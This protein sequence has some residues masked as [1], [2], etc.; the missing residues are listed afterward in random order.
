[1]LNNTKFA[2]QNI[3]K[4]RALKP[5]QDSYLEFSNSEWKSPYI[6]ELDW[7]FSNRNHYG[8]KIAY[9]IE[10]EDGHIGPFASFQEAKGSQKLLSERSDLC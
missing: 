2:K 3:I 4:A 10:S 7:P 6:C 1:M 5:F 8:S 9:W